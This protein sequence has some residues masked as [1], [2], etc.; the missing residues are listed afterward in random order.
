MLAF[1]LALRLLIW[2]GLPQ[3][4]DYTSIGQLASGVRIAPEIDAQAPPFSLPTLTGDTLT[5]ANLRGS[6]VILNF[7]ATW[8]VPCRV[9]MPMLQTLYTDYATTAPEPVRV[10]AA[11]LGETPEAARAWVDTFGLTF[12]ILL[13]ADQAVAQLY[14][15]IGQPM[16]FIIAPDGKITHIFYGAVDADTLTAALKFGLN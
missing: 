11:N 2:Q 6:W 10:V 15:L 7:W 1:W 16:T 5:L 3:R 13:D 8:C 12:D 14:R 9:E 4:A